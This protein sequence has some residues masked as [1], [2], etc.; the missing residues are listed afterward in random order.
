M[1]HDSRP[2]PTILQPRD[3]TRFWSLVEKTEGGCWLW[4]GICRPYGRFVVWRGGKQFQYKAHRLA[5][6]LTHGAFDWNLEVCHNC[7]TG[8]DP[9]CVNPAHMFL[10]SHA[11]NMGDAEQKGMMAHGDRLPQTIL[12]PHMVEAI[13]E[14]YAAGG[15]TQRELAIRYGVDQSVIS[16]IV[17][18]GIW[19]SASGPLTTPRRKQE[20]NAKL[21]E[22]QVAEIR[23]GYADAES[24]MSRLARAYGVSIATIH[25]IIHRNTWKDMPA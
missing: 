4:Q 23:R 24:S 18:G 2:Y 11:E 10:G 7:P 25:G 17:R 21:T 12:A 14:R 9:R 3:L 16:R 22:E 6:A 1:P 15:I 19:D 8:D 20:R 13:R 5:Y